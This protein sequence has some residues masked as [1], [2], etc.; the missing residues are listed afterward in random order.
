MKDSRTQELKTESQ[1][2]EGSL[3]KC[4][5]KNVHAKLM[6][7]KEGAINSARICV[8]GTIEQVPLIQYDSQ[9][10]LA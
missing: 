4:N 8:K 3:E 9:Q 2:Y 7:N 6:E 5:L 10:E 1:R